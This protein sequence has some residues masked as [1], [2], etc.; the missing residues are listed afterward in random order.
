MKSA[1][2]ERGPVTNGAAATIDLSRP[3]RVEVT[4]EGDADMLMHRWNVES[5]AAKGKAAK[6]SAAK[7]SDD[8]ESYVYRDDEGFICVP[9]EYL[10][11]SMIH[12]AKYQQDPRSPRKSAMDLSKAAI[13]SLTTLAS[14]GTKEWS[15]LHQCRVQV[16]RSGIT[17]TRPG[18]KAGWQA[19]FQLMVN[20]PEYVDPAFLRKLLND[21]GR[22]IGIGDFRPSYGRFSVVAFEVLD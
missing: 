7:K 16:Q 19:T 11:Q 18:F 10:R 13:V 3:Y 17:R 12:A 6:G 21:A 9:G 22:L 20:L 5:V 4:I 14:L 15:Y 1:V 8:V 2:L